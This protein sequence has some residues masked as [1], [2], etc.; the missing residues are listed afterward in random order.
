[1]AGAYGLQ[2]NEVV[3]LKDERVMH[4]GMWSSYTDELLLTNL[5]LVLLKKGMLGKPK[6]VLRFPLTQI[7]VYNQQAQAAIGKGM[8]GSDLLEVYFLNGQEQFAFQSGGTNKINEWIAKINQAV[9]GNEAP[10]QQSSSMALPGAEKVAGVLK[11][12]LGVFKSKF[13]SQTEAPVRIA[14]KCRG[15][16]A[17]LAGFRG[18]TITCAYCDSTQQL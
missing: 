9:T 6:D 13:G 3:L 10:V 15:C 7:K 4:G 16:G 12:T 1:M 14:G 2:P 8:T 17:P 5:N 11:D 18:Q